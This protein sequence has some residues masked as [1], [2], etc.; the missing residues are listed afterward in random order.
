MHCATCLQGT[1]VFARTSV[2]VFVAGTIIILLEIISLSSVVFTKCVQ[3]QKKKTIGISIE[4]NVHKNVRYNI[5]E[6]TLYSDCEP[7]FSE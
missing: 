1:F 3:Q 5:V 7:T 4:T 6:T 2:C